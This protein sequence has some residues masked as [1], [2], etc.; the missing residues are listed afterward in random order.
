MRQPELTPLRDAQIAFGLWPWSKGPLWLLTEDWHFDVE[1]DGIIR[2]FTIPAGYRF[3]KASIPSF[4]WGFPFNYTP[5]GLCTVAALEHDFLCDIWAGGSEWLKKQLPEEKLIPVSAAAM[6][7]HFYNRLIESGVRP[8]KAKS[9]YV[10]VA[11]FGPGGRLRP[12]GNKPSK[13][14][15]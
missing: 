9:M 14:L 15:P 10:A 12:F 4:F 8:S 3:D 6:H 11:N 7:R 2:E 13:T 1:V 5:D